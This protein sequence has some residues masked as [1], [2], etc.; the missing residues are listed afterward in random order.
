MIPLKNEVN[1]PSYL[2]HG[3]E[4]HPRTAVGIKNNK[5]IFIVVENIG[6]TIKELQ[7]I[8]LI[9]Q[10]DYFL[11][12]DGGGSSQ[13]RLYDNNQWIQNTVLEKDKTR[14]LGHAL[15]LFEN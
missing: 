2:D 1:P 9:L 7:N 8:G 13:F 14:V 5:L 3:M 11:N 15:V 12:L 6:C 4:N 10:L